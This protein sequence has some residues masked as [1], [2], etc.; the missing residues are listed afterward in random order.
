M[1]DSRANGSEAL[2]ICPDR[3]MLTGLAGV[4]SRELPETTARIVYDGYPSREELLERVQPAETGLCFLDASS[5]PASALGL[6]AALADARPA[7]A[8]I[9]LLRVDDPEMILNCL[10]QGANEFLVY[11]FTAEQLEAA[12][13][14]VWRPASSSP[15]SSQGRVISVIPGK[16]AAGA[17]TVACNLAFALARQEPR[18][19]LLADLDGLTGTVPFVL[20][21]RSNY[22]FVDA[23]AHAGSLD[24]DMWKVLVTPCRGL[25]VLLSPES[26][27]DSIGAAL[28]PAGILSCFRKAYGVTV[29]D[30]GGPY[31][32]W[33]LALARLSN[34]LLLVT[35]NEPAVLHGTQRA[36]A[37]LETNGVNPA[38]IRIVLNLRQPEA[39]LSREDS[40]EAL[41][42]SIFAVLP[43]D[44]EALRRALMEG[45]PAAPASRFGKSLAALA[46][47]LGAQPDN[48]DHT[49]AILAFFQGLRMK[50]AS[51]PA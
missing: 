16:G 13:S 29:V 20:K 28:D 51:P 18:K 34:D 41:G 45:R 40:E 38:A 17:T 12:L 27:V 31:G 5:E 1:P 25:D 46:R 50:K 36:L 15:A 43:R 3:V 7:T 11:P 19:V 44:T 47:Q 4:L 9:A 14:R 6:M 23:L 35:T 30:C 48:C 26:P 39:G 24:A 42:K 37:Y 32:G 10:R 2:L 49:P 22:S 21:L 8:V 33:N